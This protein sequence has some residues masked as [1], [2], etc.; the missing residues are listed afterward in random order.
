M[1][2]RNTLI[3]VVTL[4]AA[5]VVLVFDVALLRAGADPRAAL[6]PV[7]IVVL[8]LLQPLLTRAVGRPRWLGGASAPSTDHAAGPV[9]LP[10]PVHLRWLAAAEGGRQAPPVGGR[11]EASARRPDDPPEVRLRVELRFAGADRTAAE[12]RVLSA[13][14]TRPA[15][16]EVEAG[17]RLL[18]TEGT[19]VVADCVIA[20]V[21][22]A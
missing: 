19:R 17:D 7:V 13:D 12:L 20:A 18:I 14:A 8:A 10:R 4:V 15:P 9:D 3:L 22:R 11:Y 16:L 21:P 6:V 2:R 5:V 1:R